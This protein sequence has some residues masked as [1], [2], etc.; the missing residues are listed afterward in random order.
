VEAIIF[1]GIQATG[2][3]TFYKE[4]FFNSHVRISLD[5]LNTK[6]KQNKFLQTCLDTQSKFVIDNTSPLQKDREGI[7]QAAK[8]KKYKIVGYYFNSSIQ[9]AI[10]R[11]NERKGKAKIPE[12]GIKGCYS[13][14]Q[15]PS[16]DEGFDELYYVSIQ[17]GSFII[18]DWKNE[19]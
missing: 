12:I 9:D 4:R 11:N 8:E 2:K 19:I 3:S 15:I 17:D 6:N 5:L 13:K 18:S 10:E 1:I 7:I 14:L 16:Y